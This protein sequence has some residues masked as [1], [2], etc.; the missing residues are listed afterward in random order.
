M[1][2]QPSPLKSIYSFLL[3]GILAFSAGGSYFAFLGL[4]YSTDKDFQSRSKRR[5]H[6][7]KPEKLTVKVPVLLP[8]AHDGSHYEAAHGYLTFHGA[9]YHAEKRMIRNDTLCTVYIKYSCSHPLPGKLAELAG[10]LSSVPY[11][12]PAYAPVLEN[13][14]REYLY[15]PAIP[16]SNGHF[17]RGRFAS[18]IRTL[19]VLEGSLQIPERPPSMLPDRIPVLIQAIFRL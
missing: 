12:T 5:D 2:A 3:I 18:G 10:L 8:Y 16:G 17:S 4:R 15:S 11:S 1:E 6:L 19:R 14:S 9:C 7:N 13:L